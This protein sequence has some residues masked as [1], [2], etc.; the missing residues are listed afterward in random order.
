MKA[1]RKLKAK[2]IRVPE[3]KLFKNVILSVMTANI[4]MKAPVLI[5]WRQDIAA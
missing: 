1:P 5:A 4:A 2:Q 3:V